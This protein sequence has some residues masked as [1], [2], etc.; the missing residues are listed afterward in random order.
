MAPIDHSVAE[1]LHHL[2]RA[3]RNADGCLGHINIS[4]TR[5]DL[6]ELVAHAEGGAK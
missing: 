4:I 2:A 1:L 6:L 3:K 5:P